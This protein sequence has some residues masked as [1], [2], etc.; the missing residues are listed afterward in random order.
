MPT[1]AEKP[2]AGGL[3]ICFLIIV[4]LGGYCIYDGGSGLSDANKRDHI[5]TTNCSVVSCDQLAEGCY[6]PCSPQP[7]K[8][9]ARNCTTYD[10]I[11]S[12]TW[13]GVTYQ[14]KNRAD[15]GCPSQVTCYFYVLDISTTLGLY[16]PYIDFQ[17]GINKFELTLGIIILIIAVLVLFASCMM[18]LEECGKIP[19]VSESTPSTDHTPLA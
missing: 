16:R 19:S 12:L 2:P 1:Q 14:Q 15:I 17:R 13:N 7:C 3:F 8:P 6:S 9:I 4:A 5:V 11:F 10:L 18:A